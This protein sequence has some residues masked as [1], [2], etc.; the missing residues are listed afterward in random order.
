MTNELTENIVNIVS[1]NILT[2]VIYLLE[3]DNIINLI[4]FCDRN[5]SMQEIYRV[6]NLITEKTGKDTEIIDIRELGEFERLGVISRAKLIHSEHPIIE[7]IFMQSMAEDLK[8]A[9]EERESALE[10]RKMSGT[11]FLQ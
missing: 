2:P 4:C 10:R 6:E 1:K 7:Q 5:I 9:M 8:I 11:C 3:Q